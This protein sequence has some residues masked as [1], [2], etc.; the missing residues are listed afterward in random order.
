MMLGTTNIKYILTI[1]E[2]ETRLN[3][4]KHDDDDDDDDDDD[5]YVPSIIF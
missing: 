1:K 2:Q 3:L 4:H 5:L